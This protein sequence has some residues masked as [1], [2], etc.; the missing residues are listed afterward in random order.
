MLLKE[1]QTFLDA[2]EVEEEWKTAD[3]GDEKDERSIV[4][5]VDN[6]EAVKAASEDDVVIKAEKGEVTDARN[7]INGLKKR[8]KAA[9]VKKHPFCDECGRKFGKEASLQNHKRNVH[10]APSH[11]LFCGGL[12]C[13]SHQCFSSLRLYNEHVDKVHPREKGFECP[14]RECEQKFVLGEP[15]DHFR[16]VHGERDLKCKQCKRTFKREADRKNHMRSVHSA[17]C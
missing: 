13:Q 7:V 9:P 8:V 15:G 5:T 6:C 17:K 10:G 1:K 14:Y 4:V 16:L 3:M 2:R 11:K 12:G